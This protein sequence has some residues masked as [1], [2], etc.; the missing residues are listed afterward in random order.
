MSNV[1]NFVNGFRL[2]LSKTLC[3]GAFAR[4][5][6]VLAGG[7]ALAQGLAV[8]ASPLLTRLYSPSSFGVLA[9]Y[10]AI[11]SL[12]VVVASFRYELAIPLPEDE[13]TAGNLLVLSLAI[14]PGMAFLVGLALWLLR[15]DIAR[16]TNAPTLKSYLWL[17][18]FSFLGMGAFQAL[19]FWAVRKH[20]FSYIAQTKL[21]QSVGMVLTQIGV[22]FFALEPLG[23]LL[24]DVI[25]RLSGGT[26]LATLIWRR[27]RAVSK[28]VSRPGMRR[29]ALRYRKFPLFS[30]GS[31]LLNS[32]GLQLPALLLTALYGPQVAGLFALGQRVVGMPMTLVGQAVAQVYLSEAS[33]LGQ[34]DPSALRRLFL[35][36][37]Q[38]LLL[39]GVVPIAIIGAGGPWLFALLFGERWH[40]AGVYVQLLTLMFVIQFV[41]V[42]LSHTLNVLER[43]DL[44]LVWD[45]GRLVLVVS[46][47]VLASVLGWPAGS[48]VLVYGVSMFLAYG[49][50]FVLSLMTIDKRFKDAK[51][52][53]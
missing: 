32:A 47:I 2:F 18:P 9:A 29:A 50:L 3:G 6:A 46:G 31:A 15:D 53:S 17:L 10:T 1:V 13:E 16:W 43:Q 52:I 27:D 40:E 37:S 8:L 7:T 49:G 45:A 22:G 28:R 44:Q 51:R 11:F 39:V 33:Q 4:S 20:A 14:V 5:V 42:P 25:G 24:G 30:S 35:R 21:S 34:R 48:A 41:V 38:K 12:P 23:L 19:S 26:M 36:T